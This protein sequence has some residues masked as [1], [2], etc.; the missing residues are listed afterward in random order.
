MALTMGYSPERVV[1]DFGFVRVR[2]SLR[3][4]QQH[5]QGNNRLLLL[6]VDGVI[7]LGLTISLVVGQMFHY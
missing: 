2:T 7:C 5:S 1:G 3:T 6:E 4:F